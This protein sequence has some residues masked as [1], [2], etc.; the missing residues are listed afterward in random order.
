MPTKVTYFKYKLICIVF[1][2]CNFLSHPFLSPRA[3]YSYCAQVTTDLL[4]LYNLP[5]LDILHQWNPMAWHLVGVVSFTK[6]N[7]F[8]V[9]PFNAHQYSLFIAKQYSVVRIYCILFIR[10]RRNY[11]LNKYILKCSRKK[12]EWK[13]LVTTAKLDMAVW[14][15][16]LK[17]ISFPGLFS[18]MVQQ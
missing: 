15:W 7:V 9:N 8:E 16:D 4:C 17:K 13:N 12:L 6:Q 18:L 5:F 1:G 2:A 14:T 10:W 11:I 3:P